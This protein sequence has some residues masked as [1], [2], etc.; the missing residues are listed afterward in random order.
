MQK[1]I[2]CKNCGQEK[3]AN[4]RLKG[5]QKYCGAVECQRARKAAWQKEKMAKDADY[6]ASQHEC[7]KQWREKRPPHQYQKQYRQDH[8][9]YVSDN[10]NKQRI[11][12]QKRRAQTTHEKIVKMDALQKQLEK[13]EI[14]IMTPYKM[15]TSKK[16]VKMDT[17]LVQLQAFQGDRHTFFSSFP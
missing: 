11:R 10:R 8:P 1:T 12:N 14:Y 3:P 6:R 7:V 15:D 9:E 17:L 13:S 2:K 5:T 4:I 16:I